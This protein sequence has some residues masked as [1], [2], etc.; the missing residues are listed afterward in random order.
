MPVTA[1]ACAL[2]A[3]PNEAVQ[4]DGEEV[5]ILWD[6]DSGKEHLIRHIG[7]RGDATHFGFLVPTPGEPEVAEVEGDPFGVLFDLYY[8]PPPPPPLSRTRSR[9]SSMELASPWDSNVEV[10]AEHHVAGQTATVLRAADASALDDW[11][12][13]NGY[14]SG[15]ALEAY[16]RPYVARGWMITAFKYDKEQPQVDSPTISLSFDTDTPFFPYAEPI[17]HRPARPFR[18]SVVAPTP[19]RAHL[20]RASARGA[21]WRA[22]IGYRNEL[23]EQQ[24]VRLLDE[25]GVTLPEGTLHLTTWDEPRSRRGRRDLYFAVQRRAHPIRGRIRTRIVAPRPRARAPVGEPFR[26]PFRGVRS[27]RRSGGE[28]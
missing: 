23:I 8:R 1:W 7:F 19:M 10:V 2:V 25:A 13:E 17:G 28:S 20:S 5:L 24:R 14:P 9:Q 15:P 26:Q 4:V 22:R 21:R 18:L 12:A 16:V 11:L 3:L 27:H 6:A